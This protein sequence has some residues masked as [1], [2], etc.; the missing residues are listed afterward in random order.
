[1]K[2]TLKFVIVICSI[3][4]I[5]VL[6]KSY[7]SPTEFD[8]PLLF[9]EAREGTI[10]F[11]VDRIF[12]DWLRINGP[13]FF[14]SEH[15]YLRI[16]RRNGA[17]YIFDPG[18]NGWFFTTK[19][20]YGGGASASLYDYRRQAWVTYEKGSGSVRNTAERN[21]YDLRKRESYK[22]QINYG[23][24]YSDFGYESHFVALPDGNWM[25]FIEQGAGDPVILLHGI[26]T[27]AYLWR[28][29][30]PN[31]SENSRAIAP[32]MI[33][34]GL[35]DK[36][37]PLDVAQLVENFTQFV[38]R[39][40]LRN[41]TLVLHDWGG[42]IGFSFAAANPDRIRSLVFFETPVGP[43][44]DTSSFPPGFL[45]AVVSPIIGRDN[46]IN[47]NF[48][49]ESFLLNPEG[50]ATA[51]DWTEIEKEN[52][53]APFLLPE[54]REQLFFL[55]GHLPLLDTKGHPALD[56]DGPGGEP[57]LPS[58]QIE[59]FTNYHN[60]LMNTDVPKLFLYGVPGLVPNSEGI[61]EQLKEI[62]PNLK[63]R[64]VGS[65]EVP[66]FHFIQEDAPE[67]LSGIINQFIDDLETKEEMQGELK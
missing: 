26:P 43:F 55:A 8:R 38:K 63:A 29:I 9:D 1:M 40:N 60:Y 7:S 47:K 32:D 21:F 50:G 37:T 22:L 20:L 25:H 34:F 28:N 3:I 59:I 46:V 66:A 31:L 2:K 56:P 41:I 27:Q 54:S 52:Y 13:W 4:T 51:R 39:L 57:A 18:Y 65:L 24:A 61:A 19:R 10:D 36:T 67:Q 45:D 5:S 6:S 64:A 11:Q 62:F 12:G 42:P 49:V 44:P 48:F 35:S 15:G 14:H 58:P 53:R 23:P 33:N 16:H 30:I 17:I